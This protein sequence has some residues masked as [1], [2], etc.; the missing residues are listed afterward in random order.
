MDE[1]CALCKTPDD[2]QYGWIVVTVSPWGPRRS[3]ALP[4]AF[5]LCPMCVR[6]I[7]ERLRDIR[8]G[9][10]PIAGAVHLGDD[11]DA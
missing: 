2:G 4:P 10:R 11:D 7:A 5:V 6:T 3:D 8:D 9:G 1:A